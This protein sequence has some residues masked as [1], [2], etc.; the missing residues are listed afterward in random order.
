MYPESSGGLKSHYIAGE[1]LVFTDRYG[2]EIY[3]IDVPNKTITYASGS[4]VNYASGAQEQEAG[5]S[6]LANAGLAASAT[7][8][9]T[10]SGTKTLM[11]AHATKARGVLVVV[12]VTEV[13]AD[14]TGTQ[15]TVK[16]GETSTIEKAVAATVLVD[17]AVGTYVYGFTN[18][19]TKAILATLTAAVG[20][21]TGAVKISIIA[22]PNS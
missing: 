4:V 9:K 13:F 2:A 17:A 21:A 8:A 18:L 3:R 10:D 16:I 14:G 6:V 12:E 19:A 15:P 11:A 1:I 22:M 20:D 5:V 7:Y